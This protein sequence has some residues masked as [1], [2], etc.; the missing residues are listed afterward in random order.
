MADSALLPGGDDTIAAI[1]TPPGRSALA[2]LRLSGPQALPLL[3]ALT[4][5]DPP[6]PRQAALRPIFA[7]KEGDRIIDHALV[8]LFPG[9]RSYTGEDLVEFSVH[10]GFVVPALLLEQLLKLGARLATPGEFTRRAVLNG[11]LDLLQAEA[12]GDL[13]DSR[14]R[15]GAAAAVLLL[16]GGLSRSINAIRSSILDLEALVAYD[17]DFPEEDDGPIA[18]QRILDATAGVSSELESLLSTAGAGELLREGALVVI[19]G[20]P[21]TGKSSLFNALLGS[22]R[23]LVSEVAGTTRDA[24]EAVLDAGSWTLRLVDTAGLRQS[25]DRIEQMG[26]EVAERY[27]AGAHIILACGDSVAAVRSVVDQLRGK[28]GAQ[29]LPVLT[30][31]DMLRSG[32]MATVSGEEWSAA[33]VESGSGESSGIGGESPDSGVSVAEHLDADLPAVAVSAHSR[34]G[35]GELLA[36]IGKM[37]SRSFD[38]QLL[39]SPILLRARHE[40]ALREA[41]DEMRLFSDSLE[42][43]TLP[44]SIAATHLRSAVLALESL[45]GAVGVEDVLD[46]LFSSFCVGK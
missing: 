26:I 18:P 28:S 8:T 37:L 16:D 7:D 44:M 17:V 14:S 22:E 33:E 3:R 29:I 27:L 34:T 9:P 20:A 25:D 46:R 35:L 30:K 21:N 31:A 4:R 42:T 24:I 5:V 41:R 40:R 43:R 1:A 39:D 12:V 2:V 15:G 10:G 13:I 19:A 6:A 11:K 23:A 36:T 45:I 38:A 32:E